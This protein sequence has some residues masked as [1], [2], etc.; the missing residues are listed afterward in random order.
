VK[1][2]RDYLYETFGIT[3]AP[4]SEKEKAKRL[5][6]YL[7]GNYDLYSGSLTGQKVIWAEVRNPDSATPEKLKK[8]SQAL[9]EIFGQ[10]PV[11]Y[12][13]ENL[14]PWQRKRLIEKKVGFAEPF[15][16]LYIP[17]LF[18][19]IRDGHGKEK[20]MTKA[21][22][23][24]KAPAQFFLLY[25]LQ[26]QRLEELLLQE[27]AGLLNYSAM[28]ITRSIKELVAHALLRVE[29]TKEK[30]VVFNVHGK[31]LWEKALPFLTS[32]VRETW[33]IDNQPHNEH[34]RVGGETALAYY[35]MLSEPTQ[36]TTAIGK[37]AFRISK[38]QFEKLDKKYGFHKLEVWHYDPVLLSKGNEVDKL[39][40]YLSLKDHDDERVQG[41]LQNMINEM[42]W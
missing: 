24:L 9:Q 27:I 28:T 40:L 5:P 22:N 4:Q 20:G 26:V 17:Q 37:D 7:R 25:H 11:V 3:T 6:L 18:T 31:D 13:F 12:V 35:S 38:P 36:H 2:L 10:I 29:G 39:S 1:A 16:Q 32:P 33:Y 14:E 15:R 19:Q 34:A 41:A 21:G 42:I 8:Q 23:Q 30:T